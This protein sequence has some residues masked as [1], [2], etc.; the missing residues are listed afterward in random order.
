MALAYRD[1]TNA[2]LRR[3]NEVTIS[4]ADFLDARN[5]Q[6]VAKDSVNA[7]IKEIISYV[8]QWP[9][10]HTV[11]TVTTTPGVQEYSY[12]NDTHVIDWDS[13]FLQKDDS[14][15]PQ[16]K[17]KKLEAISLDQYNSQYRQEDEN[18][19]LSERAEPERI[20]QTQ[21]SKFGVS[22]VPDRGYTIRHT[23]FNFPSPLVNHDDTTIIP[24][25]FDFIIIEGAL[26]HMM[27]FRSNEQAVQFHNQKFRD[28][29]EY[30]R[31][32]L[33]D[34]PDEFVSRVVR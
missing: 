20:Y 4:Q 25:R 8:Q 1:L 3:I 21:T 34:F 13:F 30:M 23:Y 24:D 26:T 33:L 11:R 16:V 2:V 7:S 29:L 27:R 28:G 12:A 19:S 15:D 32:V 10:M 22:P 6:A 5:I 9:F 14:L 18:S 31:R 17:A